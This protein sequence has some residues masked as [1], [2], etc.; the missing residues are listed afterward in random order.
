MDAA[1]RARDPGLPAIAEW[2]RPPPLIAWIHGGPVWAHQS[3]WPG[4]LTS[5]LVARGFAL[6]LPNPRGSAPLLVRPT[7]T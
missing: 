2:P 5:L 6:L 3:S 1:R 4:E 7:S